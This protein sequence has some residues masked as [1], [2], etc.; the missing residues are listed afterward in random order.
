MRRLLM[1]IRETQWVVMGHQATCQEHQVTESPY[2]MQPPPVAYAYYQPHPSQASDLAAAGKKADSA[3]AAAPAEHK[4]GPKEEDD[5]YSRLEKL[6]LEQEQQRV[7]R[8]KALEAKAAKEAADKKAAEESAAALTAAAKKARAEAEAEAAAKAKT[9]KEAADKE[10]AETK[11][12]L[13]AAEA[14]KAPPDDKKPP[15]KFKDAVGRKFSFPWHICKTWRGMEELIKQAFLHVE[16][17]GP[18]VHEGHYDL[19][20]PDNE[21]IL[22]QVWEIV[23]QPDWA[24][25][26]HM[27][28]MPEPAATAKAAAPHPNVVPGAAFDHSSM[29]IVEPPPLKKGSKAGKKGSKHATASPPAVVVLPTPPPPLLHDS[30]LLMPPPLP[31]IV[32]G[33]GTIPPGFVGIDVVPAPM[34]GGHATSR[35]EKRPP[36]LPPLMAWAAGAT[37]R[38]RGMSASLKEAKKPELVHPSSPPSQQQQQQQ[39]CLVM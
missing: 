16:V 32:G 1:R 15:I 28:P 35:K 3:A 18:H 10:L 6:I 33:A 26:M 12:K 19:V 27:W 7:A 37:G 14:A 36:P 25:T 4:K 11:K 38:S 20:G 24:I 8:E 21:I 22:P 13:D 39:S 31:P 5:K 29:V 9:A 23:V 30:L 34:H 2:G 17:I